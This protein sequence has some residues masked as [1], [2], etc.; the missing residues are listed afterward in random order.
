MKPA[1]VVSLAL[2]KGLRAFAAAQPD[3]CAAFVEAVGIGLQEL[4]EE[5]MA[6]VNREQQE[7]L[8]ELR[9]RSCDYSRLEARLR[10]AELE[11]EDLRAAKGG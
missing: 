10:S 11:L 1:V 9:Q 4:G 8:R 3:A 5:F 6:L 7:E 2:A